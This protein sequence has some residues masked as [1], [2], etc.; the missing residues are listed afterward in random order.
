MCECIKVCHN[1][2][3]PKSFALSTHHALRKSDALIAILSST[4]LAN[5]LFSDV[6]WTRCLGICTDESDFSERGMNGLMTTAL[7][8]DRDAFVQC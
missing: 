4:Q 8:E 1:L 7:V 2:R 5:Q 3:N 6:A